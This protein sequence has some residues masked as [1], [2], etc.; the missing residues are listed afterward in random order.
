MKVA[1]SNSGGKDTYLAF[2]RAKALGLDPVL[3]I[4]M[5]HENLPISRS[6]AI[7]AH[8][9][10]NQ[11]YKMGLVS[12]Q[13]PCTWQGYEKVFYQALEEAKKFY[14]IKGV[15]FGDRCFDQNKAW[16]EKICLKAGLT[17]H[18]PIWLEDPN[19]L[20]QEHQKQNLSSL[21]C[22]ALPKYKNLVGQYLSD[23]ILAY[24]QKDNADIFGEKGE[25]HTLL[26]NGLNLA[27]SNFVI[28]EANNYVFIDFLGLQ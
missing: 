15:V 28:E 11:A 17:A 22:S 21:I 18:H 27:K 2:L 13:K 6:H 10:S 25:Y 14:E 9:L 1:I 7:P 20:W 26:D 8:I 19:I 16:G 5:M 24:L 4:T 12:L 23:D 3:S